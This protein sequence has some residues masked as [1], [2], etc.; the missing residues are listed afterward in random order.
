MLL[1]IV[2]CPNGSFECVFCV[3]RVTPVRIRVGV[4]PTRPYEVEA[5]AAAP[6]DLSARQS[7]AA[8]LHEMMQ[9]GKS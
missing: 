7:E 4:R 1:R 6:Q 5:G 3:S 9:A 8:L 2:L